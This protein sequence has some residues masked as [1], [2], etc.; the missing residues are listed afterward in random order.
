MGKDPTKPY[1]MKSKETLFQHL[2]NPHFK[3]IV[4]MQDGRYEQALKDGSDFLYADHSY[5]DRGWLKGHF[6][7]VRNG[8]HLTRIVKN[9]HVDRLAKFGVVLQPFKGK[10]G[11]KIGFLRTS[12]TNL[13]MHKLQDTEEELI[14]KIRNSTDREIVFRSKMDNPK[15]GVGP[16]LS[17]FLADCHAAVSVS[18]VAAVEAAVMGYP[19]FSTPHCPSWPIHAGDDIENPIIHDRYDWANSL[20]SASWHWTEA[21]FINYLRYQT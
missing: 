15:S 20:A 21:E 4:G 12:K 16:P 10:R 8:I 13:S 19:V 7:L 2:V 14:E 6:R 17:E 11:P 9:N 18:T 3:V 1:S 5:F